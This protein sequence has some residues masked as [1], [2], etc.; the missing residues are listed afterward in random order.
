MA[1]LSESEF[2]AVLSSM[3]RAIEKVTYARAGDVKLEKI[4][5]Q[6]QAVL[7]VMLD[8]DQDKPSP[9]LLKGLTEAAESLRGAGLG[10][11]KLEDD[12][13]EIEDYVTYR[14]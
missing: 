11:P 4:N 7:D 12:S 9:E 6:L 1:I 3:I 14:M 8:D 10:D 13:F 5:R 2:E